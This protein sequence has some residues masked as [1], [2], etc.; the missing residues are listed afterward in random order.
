MP[1]WWV[2]LDG[3]RRARPEYEHLFYSECTAMTATDDAA[4]WRAL[5]ETQQVAGAL[6]PRSRVVQALTPLQRVRGVSRAV[7]IDCDDGRRYVVK[8][9]QVMRPLIADHVVG[10]L[11]AIIEAPVPD[12]ALVEVSRDLI[13]PGS[14]L[15][16]F[17]PGIGHGSVFMEGCLDSRWVQYA[18]EGDN[19]DRFAT[20]AVLYGWADSADQQFLYSRNAPHLVYSVDH[21]SFFAGGPEWTDDELSNAPPGDIDRW[22]AVEA[23][24]GRESLRSAVA[25]LE[26]VTDAVIAEAVADVPAEWGIT[27]HERV[28]LAQYL[29]RR[30]DDVLSGTLI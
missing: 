11:A 6:S 23:T 12:V 27:L 4:H 30:R 15:E 21:G 25:R 3:V 2:I 18:E 10:R 7:V 14:F 19:R 8:G 13:S 5:I 17:E 20:L 29:A 1:C 16:H 26:L 9:R 22:L 24:V 28:A